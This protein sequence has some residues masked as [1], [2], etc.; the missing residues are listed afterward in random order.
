MGFE[1]PTIA[2]LLSRA[3]RKPPEQFYLELKDLSNTFYVQSDISL[4]T[5]VALQGQLKT[6][7]GTSL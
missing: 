3:T 2:R 6:A 5:F 7:R 4:G 1:P